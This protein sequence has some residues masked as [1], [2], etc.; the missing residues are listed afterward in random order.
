MTAR[1]GTT[2]ARFRVFA[3]WLARMPSARGLHKREETEC[4]LHRPGITVAVA[5]VD[6]GTERMTRG[7]SRRTN[8]SCPRAAVSD[9]AS[10]QCL[11]DDNCP[12][13]RI[14]RG[15]PDP[16]RGSAFAPGRVP[17]DRPGS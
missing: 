7:P 16:P 8:G 2:T 17:A 10:A 15:V 9:R 6:T 4:A 12:D 14:L 5:C 1:F 3:H 13:Q 11:F